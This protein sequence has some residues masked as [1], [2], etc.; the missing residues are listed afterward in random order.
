MPWLFGGRVRRSVISN[1]SPA[2]QIGCQPS[3]TGSIL[4]FLPLTSFSFSRA[5]TQIWCAFCLQN[6]VHEPVVSSL[7]LDPC[8]EVALLALCPVVAGHALQLGLLSLQDAPRAVVRVAGAID[9]HDARPGVKDRK[10][11]RLNSSHYC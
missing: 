3:G 8:G 9:D 2:V 4:L 5:K 6:L 10:S 7:G 11:K 1:S